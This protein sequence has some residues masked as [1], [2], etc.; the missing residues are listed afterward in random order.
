MEAYLAARG[1]TVTPPAAL[2]WAPSLRRLDG[3]YGPAII[4]RVD[5]I[6]EQ[7]VGIHRTWITRDDSDHWRRRDRASFGPIGGG[8]VRLAIASKTLIVGEGI[9]T[10]LAAMTATA[11]AA[12]AALSTSG[13]VA[14]VLPPI[15][16]TVVIL[17]D[18]DASGAGAAAAHDAARRWLA[19]GRHV[20]IAM[21]PEPGTDF[22]DV[23]LGHTYAR[24][25]EARDVAA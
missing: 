8:A 1:L 16:R 24:I 22:N 17:A 4:A 23:L 14:L 2:R 25:A 12:W 20:Q 10:C 6:R 15:V 19:E 9:E 18:N 7:F 11:N 5:D 13:L 21:P 3:T